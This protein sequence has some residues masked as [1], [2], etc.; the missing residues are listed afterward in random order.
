MG[1]K[2]GTNISVSF[3]TGWIRQDPNNDTWPITLFP[4]L[5][6]QSKYSTKTRKYLESLVYFQHRLNIRFLQN[7]T[8]GFRFCEI[9]K[10]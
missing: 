8:E 2:L 6:Q 1:K 10:K 5:S 7:C 4:N 3:Y 9:V